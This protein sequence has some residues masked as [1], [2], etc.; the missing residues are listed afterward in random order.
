[1]ISLEEDY[2]CARL[3]SEVQANDIAGVYMNDGR[4]AYTDNSSVWFDM[5]MISGLGLKKANTLK[6]ENT[7]TYQDCISK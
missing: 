5:S 3:A 6:A 4:V 2:E 7:L 1:M